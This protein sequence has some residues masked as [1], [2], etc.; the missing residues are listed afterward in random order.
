MID[1]LLGIDRRI[2]FVAVFLGVAIPLL[3]NLKF[4]VE[5]KKQV[6]AVFDEIEKV[7]GKEDRALV[8]LSFAYGASTEPEMQPM[9]KALLRHLFSRDVGV[10][11]VCLWPEAPGL[12]QLAL[13][14]TAAEFG[15][16]YGDDYAFMG[17]KPGTYSVIINMGQDFADAF[18]KDNWGTAT[19]EVPLTAG[20]AGLSDFDLVIDLAAGD[21]I[22]FWWL[23]FGQERYDL[24]FA[25]GCTAVMAPDLYPFLQSGQMR[26]LIGGLVGAAEYEVLIDHP[27]GASAGMSAQSV[28]HLIIVLFILIGNAAYFAARLGQRRRPE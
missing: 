19:A 9:A 18:P 11:A 7:A 15:K 4:P 1:R 3:S 8:L 17:Y 6:R 28:T 16:T 12:A 13:E 24:A 25:A 10:V 21:S 14:E 22:E 26:G 27:G 2:I 5:P 20:V 23:P